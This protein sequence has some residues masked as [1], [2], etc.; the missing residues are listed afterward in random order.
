MLKNKEKFSEKIK[1]FSKNQKNKENGWFNHIKNGKENACRKLRNIEI[2]GTKTNTFI[3]ESERSIQRRAKMINKLFFHSKIVQLWDKNL[4]FLFRQKS[5]PYRG[6]L[7]VDCR[8]K[9]SWN[10]VRFGKMCAASVYISWVG[11]RRSGTIMGR[12]PAACAARMPLY[13]S[14][15]A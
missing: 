2:D 13:E 12:I 5:L 6:R 15:M 7:C 10:A 3:W 9:N 8:F 11:G 14:S 4:Q 1:L